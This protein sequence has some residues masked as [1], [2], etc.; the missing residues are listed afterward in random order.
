M[1]YRHG[2]WEVQ[3]QEVDGSDTEDQ[4][5]NGGSG[6]GGGN[7]AGSPEPALAVATPCSSAR[8]VEQHSPPCSVTKPRVA[9]AAAATAGVA[10]VR[11]TGAAA[12]LPPVQGGSET[13]HRAAADDAVPGGDR[14]RLD[15]TPTSPISRRGSG[16]GNGDDDEQLAAAIAL[17]LEGGDGGDGDTNGDDAGG[18]STTG[19]GAEPPEVGDD[20]DDDDDDESSVSSFGSVPDAIESLATASVEDAAYVGSDTSGHD[21]NAHDGGGHDGGGDVDTSAKWRG[22]VERPGL[23]TVDTAEPPPLATDMVNG[24]MVNGGGVA[25]QSVWVPST[26]T[27]DGSTERDEGDQGADGVLWSMDEDVAEEDQG[28]CAHFA[29]YESALMMIYFRCNQCDGVAN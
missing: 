21:D 11:G 14:T 29:I 24:H 10:M 5:D 4:D 26:N 9:A 3:E 22:S 6:D 13:K 18:R 20:D 28:T 2:K 27:E 1:F 23:G 15:F 8:G 25:K 17:S 19:L 12:V 16:G 7:T